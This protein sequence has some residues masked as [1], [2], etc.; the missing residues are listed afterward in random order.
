MKSLRNKLNPARIIMLSWQLNPDVLLIWSLLEAQS[1]ISF[2][3][4]ARKPEIS[5][6][7]KIN[8][9]NKNFQAY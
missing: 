7:G 6:Q 1:Q 2:Q 4:A 8:S 9:T 3:L 5:K